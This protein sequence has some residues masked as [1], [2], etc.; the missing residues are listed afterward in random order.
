MTS[1]CPDGALMAL[2]RSANPPAPLPLP[3][4]PLVG[5]EQ[6]L[7]AVRD[8]LRRDD[9]FLLALTGP[10]GVGKTSLALGVT[11]EVAGSF[12]DGVIFVSLASIDDPALVPSAIIAALAVREAIDEPPLA[13]LK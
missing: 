6:D 7:A 9:V 13:R 1:V 10:G 2:L 3:R 5:R 8:L 11:T 12:P 4:V